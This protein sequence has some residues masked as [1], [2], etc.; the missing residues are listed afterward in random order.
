MKQ[1]VPFLA[2]VLIA[3]CTLD[4]ER[5]QDSEKASS[6]D[7]IYSYVDYDVTVDG[8]QDSATVE[9]MEKI[10]KAQYQRKLSVY[11]ERRWFEE[12]IC[13]GGIDQT[14]MGEEFTLYGPG[15]HGVF[16]QSFDNGTET[17]QTVEVLESGELSYQHHVG[18]ALMTGFNMADVVWPVT[19]HTEITWYPNGTADGQLTL[20]IPTTQGTIVRNASI[21]ITYTSATPLVAPLS[22]TLD[23]EIDSMTELGGDQIVLHGIRTVQ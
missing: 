22:L 1:T 10:R 12:I 2:L 17:E 7:M 14:A 6:N 23:A 4:E 3:S 20:E 19:K 15:D 13:C 16:V 5:A 11:L 8:V 21:A 9:I 18:G